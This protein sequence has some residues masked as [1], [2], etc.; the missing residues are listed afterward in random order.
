MLRISVAHLRG[1]PW[2]SGGRSGAELGTAADE[3]FPAEVDCLR[4]WWTDNHRGGPTHRSGGQPVRKKTS[5][6]DGRDATGDVVRGKKGN[7]MRY[8]AMFMARWAVGF[9]AGAAVPAAV[10]TTSSWPTGA[11]S[12]STRRC[13]RPRTRRRRRPPS[14]ARR[15]PPRRPTTPS[16]P[17]RARRTPPRRRRR[18]CRGSCTRPRTS[19][20]GSSAAATARTTRRDDVAA[21]GNLVYPAD[22]DASAA[23]GVRYT[24]DTPDG[25]L[26]PGGHR[27]ERASHG[28]PRAAGRCEAEQRSVRYDGF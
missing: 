11:R 8:K 13:R 21:D 15:P 9:V 23:N 26:S 16:P 10:L 19:C 18:R 17:R 24:P 5:G 7:Q 27:A 14:W 2:H 3:L 20:R 4:R 25:A 12:P 28:Q 22:G 6:T 1:C